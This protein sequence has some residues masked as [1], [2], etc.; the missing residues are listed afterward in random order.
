MGGWSAGVQL[1]Q[2]YKK[3]Y[4]NQI[5]GMIFLDGYPN[6]LALIGIYENKSQPISSNTIGTL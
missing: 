6:Y 2:I 5:Q 3:N 1:S 4:P